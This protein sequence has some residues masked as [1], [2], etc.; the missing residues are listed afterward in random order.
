MLPKS[1]QMKMNSVQIEEDDDD[2]LSQVAEA[3]AVALSDF[4]SNKRR[5]DIYSGDANNAKAVKIEEKEG[6]YMAA[7]RGSKSLS[8]QQQNPL[9]NSTNSTKFA[10][11][12]PNGGVADF[13]VSDP[14][15]PDKSCPCCSG[16]CS[17]FTAN[18]ERNQG[19][20]FYRCPVRQVYIVH[21]LH[22]Y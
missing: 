14:L 13:T 19:R 18:T 17:I 3:E 2:F 21:I 16:T 1:K 10:H 6:A 9:Q 11:R 8:W 5:R 20:K 7:L 22:I 15:I 4:N 12:P